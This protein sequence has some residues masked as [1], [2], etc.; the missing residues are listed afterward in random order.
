MIAWLGSS[1]DGLGCLS[2]RCGSIDELVIDAST[3]IEAIDA[4][5]SRYPRRLI[6]AIENRLDYPLAEIQY[7]QR[8]WPEV[9][10]ALA[11]GS[12]F[13]GS[14]RTGIGATSHLSLPWY[15][16]LDGWRPWLSGSNVELLNPWPQVLP[17]KAS[18]KAASEVLCKTSGVILCD[19]RQ[20]AAAWQAGIE[21]DP[22]CTQLLTLSEFREL[23]ARPSD[24][25]TYW[26]LW[27]DSCLDTFAGADC[28]SEVGE[29]FATIRKRFPEA[30]ILAATCMPRWSDW[31]Q[32]K[33]AGAD[34]LI[35][36]P[37]QGFSLSEV[38]H[39]V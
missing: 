21:C 14:R 38:L 17:G 33:L 6:L 13:D 7:L 37:C 30:I 11:F 26:I 23:V 16:W 5:C 1:S 20:T 12:W 22:A 19:C 36:K 18:G 15:R 25:E 39:F 10:C 31:Q 35:A 29:L 32:W 27:D 8:S 9:P 2:E 28:L 24:N 34:E 4:L 3:S